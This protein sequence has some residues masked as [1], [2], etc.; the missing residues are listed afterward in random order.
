MKENGH[1]VRPFSDSP[2]GCFCSD[3]TAV[4]VLLP[5]AGVCRV[6][7]IA[8]SM[9]WKTV[10]CFGVLFVTVT[11]PSEFVTTFTGVAD[12]AAADFVV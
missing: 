7:C 9:R 11:V 3:G 2:Y 12:V 1:D 5:V 8:C 4:G 10:S 6:R